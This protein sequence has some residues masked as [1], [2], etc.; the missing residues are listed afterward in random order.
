MEG[1]IDFLN[2]NEKLSSISLEDV[3]PGERYSLVVKNRLARSMNELQQKE[4]KASKFV[5]CKNCFLVKD[6][7]CICSD[8]LN[9]SEKAN[10]IEILPKI[11]FLI[12]MNDRELFK[13]SNTGKLIKMLIPDSE[14]F[15]HGIPEDNDRLFE[16]VS[17][18]LEKYNETIILFPDNKSSVS[19]HACLDGFY[20]NH[21][22]LI[23]KGLDINENELP[24][25]SKESNFVNKHEYY[26]NLCLK[27]ILIDGTWSQAKTI[28]KFLPAN[29]PRVVI[30]S[31]KISDFGPLRKQNKESNISTIEAASLLLIDIGN[32]IEL[33]GNAIS[34]KYNKDLIENKFNYKNFEIISNLLDE[35]LNVLIINVISQCKREYLRDILNERNK[36]RFQ[37]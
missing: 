34:E 1:L 35:S 3:S 9:L 20:L 13:S 6:P 16:R 11:K 8:L 27:V 10:K 37:R 7:Y 31:K 32:Y 23:S 18:N 26:S 24:K 14:I 21:L 28:N 12:L 4:L 2:I 22:K 33:I 29:I 17:S 19:L 36:K 5:K 30:R 25:D 15:I